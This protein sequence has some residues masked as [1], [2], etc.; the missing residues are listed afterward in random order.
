MKKRGLGMIF[1]PNNEFK[2]KESKLIC[3]EE[4]KN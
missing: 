1:M 2:V 3:D 4:A